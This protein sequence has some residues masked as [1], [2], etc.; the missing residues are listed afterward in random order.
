MIAGLLTLG[1]ACAERA[2][3][4]VALRDERVHAA[5]LGGHQRLAAMGLGALGIEPVGMGRDVAEQ[6]QSVAHEIEAPLAF[7]EPAKR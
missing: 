6:V 3:A 2:E 5:R 1:H 7:T 4:E